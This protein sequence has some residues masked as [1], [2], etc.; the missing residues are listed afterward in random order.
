MSTHQGTVRKNTICLN[1]I[2]KDEAH[3]IKETLE[4]VVK[5]GIDYYVISDTGSTDNTK[6]IIKEYFNVKGIPGEVHDDEWKDFGH[7]RSV[8]LM[9]ARGKADYAWVIDADDLVVGDLK[10]PD[11]M[12]ADCYTLT[13][14]KGFTYHRKQI[15]KLTEELN[16][17]YEDV[18]HEYPRADKDNTV[19]F[20][21][22]GDYYID[23]RRLGSRNKDPNKYLNDAKTFEKAIA[24]NPGDQ[25]NVRR[26]FYLAQSYYDQSSCS[27]DMSYTEKSI[28][29]YKKRISMEDWWE[30]VYYSYYKIAEGFNRLDKSWKIIEKA[31]LDAYE[32]SKKFKQQWKTNVL[33]AEPLYRM[34]CYLN[35]KKMKPKLAYKYA[36]EASKIPYPSGCVLFVNRDVYEYKALFELA[37][38]SFNINKYVD[39]YKICK[40]IMLKKD[41]PGWFATNVKNHMD[42]TIAKLDNAE[43]E[44][45]VIYVGNKIISNDK[46]FNALID[47][48]RLSFNIY[49]VGNKIDIS[50][51]KYHNIYPTTL[52]FLSTLKKD[53]KFHMVMM[54][55]NIDFLR[56]PG[57]FSNSYV[58]LYQVSEY[59]SIVLSNGLTVHIRNEHMLNKLLSNVAKIFC[60]NSLKSKLSKN[61][62]FKETILLSDTG[63]FYDKDWLK[64]RVNINEYDI[65]SNGIEFVLPP[66]IS[67]ADKSLNSMNIKMM[68]MKF[69]DQCI[70]ELGE[71]PEAYYYYSDYYCQRGD[72]HIAH[73]KIEKALSLL[74]NTNG[75][76]KQ[77]LN[78]QKAKCLTGLGKYAE[79][80][81][82]AHN[83]Y[84]NLKIDSEKQR[85]A[86]EDIRDANIDGIKDS[87]LIYPKNKIKTICQ[88]LTNNNN[89]D[90]SKE[91]ISLTITTCKRYDNFSKTINSFINC[92]TDLNKIGYWLC[93]DDNS[94]E[95]DRQKMRKEYPFFNYIMKGESD[96]GHFVS[97]NIIHDFITTNNI[98]YNL[99]LEDD[100]HFVE[101][102]QYIMDSVNILADD[103]T[104]GQVLFNRNY[105][106]VENC[107]IRIPGGYPKKTKK[108]LRYILHEHYPKDTPEYKDFIQRNSGYG[109]NG[110]WPYFSFRPS[111]WRGSVFKELGIFCNTPHFEM[112][113]AKE[114]KA[115]GYKSAFFDT[116]CCIHIGKKTWEKN[117]VNS[118]VLNSTNQFTINNDLLNVKILRNPTTES[119]KQ[120]KKVTIDILP[121]VEYVDYEQTAILSK[122]DHKLLINNT[123][124]YC[125]DTSTQILRHKNIWKSFRSKYCM[126][127]ND[128]VVFQK[129]SKKYFKT[130]IDK[131]SDPNF[132]TEFMVLGYYGTDLDNNCTT[133]LSI[134]NIN[135]LNS[136]VCGYIVSKEAV[137]KLLIS[138]ENNKI[139][140]NIFT[141]ITTDNVKLER[142]SPLLISGA[143]RNTG[144]HN[145]N[146][147]GYKFY[148]QMDSH[149]NDIKCVGVKP[150]EELKK[151]ADADDKCVGFNTLG[152]LK[153]RLVPEID[154]VTL[155]KSDKK[156]QGLY[157]KTQKSEL[158]E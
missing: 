63:R 35:S 40:Q 91:R 43:K 136:N 68:Q 9:H 16:W 42:R 58:T 101:S 85:W 55:D 110:Y 45:C 38:C 100:F 70:G 7:N 153:Y 102:R 74:S 108:G 59:F 57:V 19:E 39:S 14:G 48:I 24:E 71:F 15:F 109:T 26:T 32:Y 127:I 128:D 29:I 13:Y 114:Y 121:Y 25:K 118:Y 89:L 12:T 94:S 134:E 97:M 137:P 103:E 18:L 116:F 113:Y 107:K 21:I 152:W 104:L 156:S 67:R 86:I 125:R 123:F 72:Y 106:E 47:E 144:S 53:M 82:L 66:S 81:R 62:G 5:Y 77:M 3:I 23:S 87:T 117:K 41:L 124:N 96:K 111:M 51:I 17:H 132:S 31:Y 4:N 98:D 130:I 56:N 147:D 52:E 92:C 78:V 115:K 80:Y 34:A 138:I 33:R 119:L 84:K 149:G 141:S 46:V 73:Q 10:F 133:D 61:Y 6:E 151:I 142:V 60:V 126:I 37:I 30:E 105:S 65:M 79:S 95:E 22:G 93:V 155:Y 139:T 75:N 99:H 140:D 8:A 146:L 1:M 145:E 36:L 129:D 83:V 2:V 135:S 64:Y 28:D 50:S 120:F 76:Y 148:S 143:I 27:K 20:H 154:F 131:L 49:L 11:N 88:N 90:K 150:I 44:N 112:Q 122:E 158:S 54:Y 69:Y 157:V